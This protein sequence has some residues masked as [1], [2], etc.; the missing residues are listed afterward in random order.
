MMTMGVGEVVERME[1]LL[2]CVPVLVRNMNEDAWSTPIAPGKWSP[3]QI[4]GHLVDSAANNHQRII[5]A[6]YQDRP[7]ISYDQVEWN[8]LS[9]YDEESP[10]TILALWTAYN[11][12]LVHLMRRLTANDLS[13]RYRVR[14]DEYPLDHLV[15]DYL[16]HLE[17][18]LH[19]F[20]NY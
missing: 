12:H 8:R 13:K 18:H 6:R 9:A 16:I 10:E 1:F 2:E 14:D 19:Q 7:E 17:H 20:L 5:R 4:L 15:S 3:R 11:R